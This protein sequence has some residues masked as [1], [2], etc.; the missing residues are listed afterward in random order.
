M[1]ARDA[2]PALAAR[3][4][5]GSGGKI[6]AKAHR[7]RFGPVRLQLGAEPW[8]SR[9]ARRCA[10]GGPGP[11]CAGSR[12]C[13]FSRFRV[14]H[15]A[16][17]FRRRLVLSQA[18]I[19]DLAEQIVFRPGEKFHLGDELG[20]YPMHVAKTSGA[21]KRRRHLERHCVSRDWGLEPRRRRVATSTRSS[22]SATT[23]ARPS[24]PARSPST[25][26]TP[27]SAIPT[28]ADTILDRL[29]H[30]A[31]GSISLARASDADAPDRSERIDHQPATLPKI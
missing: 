7:A 17:Y 14:R 23:A 12:A 18:L 9:T 16:A 1:P 20:P 10:S 24:S 27:S 30:N 31:I 11:S 26:G 29:V 28:Y 13:R 4:G 21:P 6:E 25:N 22:K 15:R 19:D 8:T 5:N 3:P 2:G